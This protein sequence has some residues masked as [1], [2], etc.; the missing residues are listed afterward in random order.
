MK[1]QDIFSYVSPVF[2]QNQ[3]VCG[4]G[5]F[6]GDHFITAGHVVESWGSLDVFYKNKCIQLTPSILL[7]SVNNLNSAKDED[8]M[9]YAVFK[10]E[11][12]NSPLRLAEK[13]VTPDI[14][15]YL[16]FTFFSNPESNGLPLESICSG[17]FKRSVFNFFELTMDRQDIR[18]G[19]SGSPVIKDGILY[20]IL[21]G[22][23]SEKH[24]E[25][26]L[27]QSAHK[28]NY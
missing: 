26:I 15:D 8:I 13:P 28:V 14:D 16:C 17:Q 10:V 1:P 23:L 11:G 9:D 18:E 27:F 2:D 20:G 24:P 6:V 5:C 25:D 7:K 3:T 19:N 21:T 12:V 4:V 22:S